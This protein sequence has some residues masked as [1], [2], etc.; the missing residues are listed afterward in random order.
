MR[1]ALKLAYLG[2]GYYGYQIQ[3]G[4][5]TI[6]GKILKALRDLGA[7]KNPSKARYSA[8]GRTDRGVHALCQVIVFDTEAPDASMPRALSSQL[9]RIWAYAWAQVEVDFNA[10]KSAVERS[11]IAKVS[12]MQDYVG[13]RAR[14]E[15][16]RIVSGPII[17]DDGIGVRANVRHNALD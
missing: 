3:P 12:G 16:A 4:V 14:G 7:V 13:T 9:E 6:E 15:G 11:I 2:T 8:A 17:D 1:L 5:P 10:R